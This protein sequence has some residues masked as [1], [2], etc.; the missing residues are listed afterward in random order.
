MAPGPGAWIFEFKLA[1]KVQTLAKFCQV[2]VTKSFQFNFWDKKEKSKILHNIIHTQSSNLSK[3]ERFVGG[4]GNQTLEKVTGLGELLQ[5]DVRDQTR[6]RGVVSEQ[7]VPCT[8]ELSRHRHHLLNQQTQ[9]YMIIY[10]YVKRSNFRKSQLT[11]FSTNKN[12]Y[13]ISRNMAQIY[14]LILTLLR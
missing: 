11:R 7:D 8:A 13:R 1:F 14:W 9:V 10:M 6:H 12:N 4:E 5:L 3:E 2:L